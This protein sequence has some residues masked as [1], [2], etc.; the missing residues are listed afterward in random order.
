MKRLSLHILFILTICL[1][2]PSAFAQSSSEDFNGLKSSKKAVRNPDNPFSFTISFESFVT[3]TEVHGVSPIDVA[4]IMDMS[5]SMAEPS[6]P[7]ESD[8]T[9]YGTGQYSFKDLTGYTD[10][11][12]WHQGTGCLEIDNISLPLASSTVRGTGY[13][14]DYACYNGSGT[15]CYIMAMREDS[16]TYLFYYDVTT[17]TATLL[18]KNSSTSK[19][20]FDSAVTI[21]H[22]DSSPQQKRDLLKKAAKSFADII[23]SGAKEG[24]V[25]HRISAVRYGDNSYNGSATTI[26][27]NPSY[28]PGAAVVKQFTLMNETGTANLNA[29][30]TALGNMSTGGQTYPQNGVK[31]A[32]ELFSR[33][34][35]ENHQK[36]VVF[37]TDGEPGSGAFNGDVANS[38]VSEILNLKSNGTIVYSVGIFNSFSNKDNTYKFMNAFSSNYPTASGYSAGD[39]EAHD[40][41]RV[42]GEK[43]LDDIFKDIAQ[44]VI[45]GGPAVNV[46]S[47]NSYVMDYM[48]PGFHM[49]EGASMDDVTVTAYKC[50]GYNA[51]TDEYS[52]VT[53]GVDPKTL[54][55]SAGTTVVLDS[56]DQTLKVTGFDYA[57]NYVR[58]I[59]Q[60]GQADT[61]DGYKL[62]ISIPV[63]I[64]VDNPGGTSVPTNTTSS[65]LY[66]DS[67]GDGVYNLVNYF[68]V[69]YVKIPN[70]VVV[71]N[72]MNP[73][74]SALIK[75]ECL[76][77][78]STFRPLTLVLSPN[79]GETSAMAV[80]KFV[81]VGRYRATEL[82]WSWAYDLSS[83][84]TSAT[85]DDA[86]VTTAQWNAAGYGD[87][88]AG[89]LYQIPASQG[90]VKTTDSIIRNVNDF[91]AESTY[92]GTL[93]DFTNT[94]KA[95]TPVH[96]ED[97]KVNSLSSDKVQST[98]IVTDPTTTTKKLYF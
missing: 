10:V 6:A 52:F 97:K 69:P 91:T 78:G 90:T 89:Y 43:S 2:Q 73:G 9:L 56:S 86:E 15:L 23:S 68:D 67:D 72:G 46:N 22:T 41:F 32:E 54:T 26:T 95:S 5:Q 40:Y 8:Y 25:D 18:G 85:H 37:M 77:A 49:P 88:A 38:A 65:G 28:Q 12:L 84:G 74:E 35:V 27:E 93:F 45:S 1:V 36:V 33:Q 7:G 17:G 21:Y 75:V 3:G 80:I 39:T 29:V 63:E 14:T 71:K 59:K 79:E 16:V 4:L 62:C 11:S 96:G 66:Y 64:D 83:M 53:T 92:N 34:G 87:S 82:G 19:V 20:K 55:N 98:I 57:S 47:S 42:V 30:K 51:T 50:N 60:S 24:D 44:E 58:V 70:L 31:L 61:Y 76:D 13:A 94:E 81:Q 48:A